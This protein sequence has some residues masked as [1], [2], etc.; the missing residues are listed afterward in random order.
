MGRGVEK[1]GSPQFLTWSIGAGGGFF[2]PKEILT[3]ERWCAG[4]RPDPPHAE[5]APWGAGSPYLW[6]MR[7][8]C[9][10]MPTPLGRSRLRALPARSGGSTCCRASP[11]PPARLIYAAPHFLLVSMPLSPLPP[12]PPLFFL[13]PFPLVLPVHRL[14]PLFFFIFFFPYCLHASPLSQ[15]Y[16]GLAVCVRSKWVFILPEEVTVVPIAPLGCDPWAVRG[17]LVL[18]CLF[19][20]LLFFYYFYRGR[21]QAMYRRG[22][23][24]WPSVAAEPAGWLRGAH[25]LHP[26]VAG[27]L[28]PPVRRRPAGCLP[29]RQGLPGVCEAARASACCVGFVFLVFFKK[30]KFHFCFVCPHFICVT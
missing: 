1:G 11:A 22:G 29:W 27:H 9:F 16:L 2:F 12:L 7:P 13:F 3:G 14:T 18:F 6:D 28:S 8:V 10:P 20:F 4:G 23:C 21:A 30:K 19:G 24:R 15:Q 17:G 5:L 26:D 25:R